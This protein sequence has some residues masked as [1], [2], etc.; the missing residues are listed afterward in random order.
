MSTYLLFFL[1]YLFIPPMAWANGV[2]V[3]VREGNTV[4]PIENTDVRM[5]SEEVRIA[6]NDRIDAYV[7]ILFVFENLSDKDIKFR[8]GFPLQKEADRSFKVSVGDRPAVVKEGKFVIDEKEIFKEYGGNNLNMY[9]W[10]ITFTAK[11]KKEVRV[12]YDS[13]WGAGWPNDEVEREFWY[14]TKT[15]SLWRDTIGK[16]DFYLTLPEHALRLLRGLGRY[17]IQIKP[18]PYVR[19]ENTIEWHF[20]DW[21]PDDDIRVWIIENKPSDA[22]F[23]EELASYYNGKIYYGDQSLYT[24]VM[25][26]ELYL[27]PVEK[28][29]K[30]DNQ[31]RLQARALR[32]EIYA[33]HGKIFSTP[34]M[35][36]IFESAKWYKPRPDFNER[37]LNAIEKKNIQFIDEYEKRKGW[38]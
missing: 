36:R 19:K 26:Y 9:Y 22:S 29:L 24:D 17:G 33:R 32:N 5:V 13:E 27:G 35:K 14:I 7:R 37:A 3:V 2:G 10:D 21:K 16:A 20:T 31:Q 12:E 28:Y 15:G 25:F 1:A 38:K 18:E 8:M 11:E 23:I 4:I 6:P 34:E 30:F